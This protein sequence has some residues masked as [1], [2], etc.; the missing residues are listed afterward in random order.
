MNRYE[1]IKQMNFDQMAYW[2]EC[3]MFDSFELS[4]EEI[5]KYL[6]QEVGK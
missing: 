4:Y 6:E 1:Q 2:L 3:L 5:V